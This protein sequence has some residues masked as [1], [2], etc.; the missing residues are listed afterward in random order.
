VIKIEVIKDEEHFRQLEPVWNNLVKKS[1]LTVVYLTYEWLASWWK[2]CGNGKKLLIL[3]I[4]DGDDVIG[5]A[6]FMILT[7]RFFGI[8]ISVVEFI[9][10]MN[11]ADSPC[12]ISGSLDFIITEKHDQVIQAIVS[13]LKQNL[14]LWHFVRLNPIPEK[15]N[16]IA[17]L[18]KET[19]EHKLIFKNQIVYSNALVSL[20]GESKTEMLQ[21]LEKN[22][23]KYSA[24]EKKL[25]R[26]GEVKY[27][28]HRSTEGVSYEEVLEI[29]K[30][31]WKWDVGI[32]INS[33]VYGDFYR[34]IIDEASKNGWLRLWILEVDG[35]IIAYDLNVEYEGRIETLKGSFN[36]EYCKYSPG[37]LLM[38]RE[39]EQF[40]K[41]TVKHVNLLWGDYE[42]KKR[43]L[44]NLDQHHELFIFNDRLISKI[45]SFILFQLKFQGKLRHI[46]DIRKRLMRK[47]NIRLRNSE[48]TRMDQIIN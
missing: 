5:I 22:V 9:S 23:D 33:A 17:L 14:N 31:S 29:E 4:S 35:K 19:R 12:N 47:M 2:A 36:K 24:I 28:E 10:M 41:D 30:K 43:W 40:S 7:K 13:F 18:E 21:L 44:A 32:S 6:P 1:A 20:A 46:S 16:S 34:L 42:S 3:K 11:Y 27:S 25:R 39:M 37:T 15:S 45:I 8:P 26:I 48:L 38:W